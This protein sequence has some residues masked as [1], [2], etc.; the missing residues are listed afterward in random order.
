MSTTTPR[1][2]PSRWTIARCSRVCGI[3]PSSAAITSRHDVDAADPGEHVLD[4]A[5]VPGHVD[6]PDLDPG[7][8]LE[9]REAEIDRDA[10][11]LLLGQTIGVDAGE[12]PHHRDLAVVDVTGRA[13]HGEA[14]GRG[15]GDPGHAREPSR[16]ERAP[17]P[18]RSTRGFLAPSRKRRLRDGLRA[19]VVAAPP[20]A[21]PA[22][23]EP[24]PRAGPRR[25]T[26]DPVRPRCPATR[27]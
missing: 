7:R 24:S 5:L 21:I 3:T 23:F 9:R 16:L 8:R 15:S 10:A 6:D 4:E 1:R 22:A 18:C 12:A 11:L 25:D 26:W 20:E 13:H 27:R 14:R 2:M 17:P 19:D